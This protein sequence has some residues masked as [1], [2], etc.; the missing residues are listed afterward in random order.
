[1]PYKVSKEH[2]IG[3]GDTVSMK[4]KSGKLDDKTIDVYV[5]SIGE[6][7]VSQDIYVSYEYLDSL[8]IE[9]DINGYYITATNNKLEQNLIDDVEDIENIESVSIKEEQKEDMDVLYQT[10]KSTVYIMIIMSA[11]LAL[12]VIFNISSINIFE[13][14]RDI[15]TLKVLGYHKREIRSLVNVEN[16]LITALGCIIGVVFGSVLYKYILLAVESDDMYIPYHISI[17]MILSSVLLTFCFTILTNF[18]LRGK[19]NK[20]DMVESLKSV[21]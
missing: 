4:I 8:D 3:V 19:T 5:A 9:T 18:L 17:N 11:A 16:L 14:S 13:R 10:T 7:Y 15:A 20:I 1:F 2:D 6:M 21:E 12:A